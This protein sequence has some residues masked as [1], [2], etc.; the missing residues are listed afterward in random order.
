MQDVIINSPSLDPT[1]NVSGI[2][3]VVQF[4]INNNK[5]YNYIH[6]EVGRTDEAKGGLSRVLSIFSSLRSWKKLLHKHP[7]AIVHYNFAMTKKCIIRDSVYLHYCKKHKLVLHIHG[8]D[9]LFSDS[10]PF[11]LNGLLKRLFSKDVPFVVLSE[12]EKKR[13]EERYQA[14]AVYS[15][16][17]CIDLVD[18]SQYVKDYNRDLLTLGYIGRVS[19]PKGMNELLEACTI[20]KNEKFPFKL[21]IAG[22]EREGDLYLSRFADELGDRFEYAGIVSGEAKTNFLK[23]ID[24]F[25]LP[26]YFEGLP[27]SLLETMSFG[28]VPI[29]TEVGS[30]NTVVTNGEN[31]LFITVKSCKD[32]VEKVKRLASEDGLLENLGR[33]AKETIFE[34]FNPERYISELNKI[35][36][37]LE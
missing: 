20:L 28:C 14:R 16:P 1:K 6:F 10:I 22:S 13:I 26:S 3:S 33:K 27:I 12:A 36:Q 15:L 35:Y 23:S 25:V 29:T 9:F 5:S 4:I 8:G 37:D 17:N 11:Y 21:V 18:A 34:R 30:I 31:G 32:I 7:D 19:S 2:S 24:I